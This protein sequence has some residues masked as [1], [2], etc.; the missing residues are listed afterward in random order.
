[1]AKIT[2]SYLRELLRQY[3]NEEISISRFAELINELDASFP[4][5]LYI[6][7]KNDK[8]KVLTYEQAKGQDAP[9]LL[10]NGYIHTTTL[11]PN[12]FIEYLANNLEDAVPNL[13]ELQFRKK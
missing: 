12:I 2:V 8:V 9:T 5:E 13:I 11:E 7:S 1:M 6:Y 10:M 4:S 3:D